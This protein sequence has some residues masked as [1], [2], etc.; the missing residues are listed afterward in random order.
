MH[1]GKGCTSRQENL[2][3]LLTRSLV[4]LSTCLLVY[5][6]ILK[7]CLTQ[8]LKRSILVFAL[9]EERDVVL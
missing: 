2:A 3:V 6:N 7:Q 8:S 4:C 9:D 1:P 5:F